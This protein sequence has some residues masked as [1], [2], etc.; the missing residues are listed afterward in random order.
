MRLEVLKKKK[1]EADCDIRKL[2]HPIFAP[3]RSASSAA[4]SKRARKKANQ[5]YQTASAPLNRPGDEELPQA[6]S[7]RADGESQIVV[8]KETGLRMISEGRAVMDVVTKMPVIL[9]SLGPDY[10]MAEFSPGVPPDVRQSL[11]FPSGEVTVQS[12]ITGLEASIEDLDNPVCDAS[13]DFVIANRDYMGMEMKK[14]LTTLK[15]SAQSKNDKESALHLK[16]VRDAFL[17]L[18]NKV[19]APF[20]QMVLDAEKS[21]GPNFANLEIGS[22]VGKQSY[23]RAASWIV[24]QAM[25][26]VWE[27][28][29][30]D[31]SYYENTVQDN[32]NTMEY[33]SAGDPNRF[34]PDTERKFYS[35][36]E[37]AKMTAWAQKM[38]EA[39]SKDE[40]LM[41]S[42]PPEMRFLD[43]AMI[44]SGGTELRKFAIDEFCAKEGIQI[45]MLREGI[46]RLVCQLENM[47]PD[48]Y[49]KLTRI[50]SDLS[51]ALAVGSEDEKNIYKDYLYTMNES[52]P[53][54]F[55]TYS[56]EKD[57]L[58][59]LRF[60]D[61]EVDVK[62]GGL[63]PMDEVFKQLGFGKVVNMVSKDSDERPVELGWLDLLQK[64]EEEKLEA[65]REEVEEEGD[66]EFEVDE[67]GFFLPVDNVEQ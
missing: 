18:E 13:L 32:S 10:R 22:Y 66:V 25:R 19:S 23:Q 60:L 9:S 64:E 7:D 53:G 65:T 38:S 40:E 45:E 15:L 48:P 63:G 41:A 1:T 4:V 49:G 16:S 67:E 30:R 43:K 44:I 36:E 29:A 54:F 59:M 2:S 12:L 33:L 31:A 24:L 26:A 51:N 37:T 5:E 46:R 34:N 50:I 56:M 42:L 3:F 57:G 6:V 55:Q 47:Q 14:T 61:N 21:I 52:G 27:K 39:F 20:R 58:S 35:Y 28:K 62:Q 8:D 11:R 17:I